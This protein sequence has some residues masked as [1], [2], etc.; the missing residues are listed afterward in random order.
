MPQ[1]KVK[2]NS[3]VWQRTKRNSMNERLQCQFIRNIL[4]NPTKKLARREF[5]QSHETIKSSKQ[6]TKKN[7]IYIYTRNNNKQCLTFSQRPAT[8]SIPLK[9]VVARTKDT[10]RTGQATIRMT[11]D[12]WRRFFSLWF[13]FFSSLM[14]LTASWHI[15][16]LAWRMCGRVLLS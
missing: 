3:S 11:N 4:K 13:S 5:G 9:C 16:A 1:R 8:Y 2:R 14:S 7:Y 6:S 10:S 15:F 12:E